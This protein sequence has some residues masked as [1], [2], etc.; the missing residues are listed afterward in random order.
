MRSHGNDH[1][2]APYGFGHLRQVGDAFTSCGQ[3]A[4]HW[5]IFW[6]LPVYELG[7]LCQMC[8][9]AAALAPILTSRVEI[10]QKAL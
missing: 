6:D 3:P 7:E 4:M 5:Q 9:K 1:C 8:A 2:E 10:Q